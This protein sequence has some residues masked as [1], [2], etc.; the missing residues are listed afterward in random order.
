MHPAPGVQT[1]AV[2]Y[3]PTV[4]AG[5]TAADAARYGTAF[6]GRENGTN[7]VPVRTGF[8]EQAEMGA[9]LFARSSGPAFCGRT[10]VFF[11]LQQ[12]NRAF[13]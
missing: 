9:Y 10:Y 2:I 6:G 8:S 12:Y 11:R 4:A 13:P 3:S 5:K 1:T 7:L